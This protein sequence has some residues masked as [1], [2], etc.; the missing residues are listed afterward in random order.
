MHRYAVIEVDSYNTYSFDI[1][2]SSKC[3][4]HKIVYEKN[5]NEVCVIIGIICS[6]NE[7]STIMFDVLVTTT[8]SNSELVSS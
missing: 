6:P 2:S 7:S 3:V 1:K 8:L 4:L 5:E